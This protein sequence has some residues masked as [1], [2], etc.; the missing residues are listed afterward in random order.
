MSTGIPEID[1]APVEVD[2]PAYD[3]DTYIDDTRDAT[4]PSDAEVERV[5]DEIEGR[6]HVPAGARP[7][8][9]GP[10]ERGLSRFDVDRLVQ[11]DPLDLSGAPASQAA[12][13]DDLF[14]ALDALRE[15]ESALGMVDV[16]RRDAERAAEHT[17]AEALAAG[18]PPKPAKAIDRDGVREHRQRVVRVAGGRL[19]NAR[20]TYDAAVVGAQ[21]ARRAAL[22]DEAATARAE[23]LDLLPVAAAAFD[24]WRGA[25][26]AREQVEAELDP[27]RHARLAHVDRDASGVLGRGETALAAALALARSGH[28]VLNG[29]VW[30]ND[31]GPAVTPAYVRTWAAKSGSE[32]ALWWLAV[33]E[34]R[35]RFKVSRWTQGMSTLVE[36]HG[37]QQGPPIPAPWEPEPKR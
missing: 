1:N 23:V 35:E 8:N 24:R 10:A 27:A 34:Y 32:A 37:L 30:D 15:A 12:A 16:E 29:T 36:A 22:A 9:V 7:A 4:P 26:R 11:V 6:S 31:P 18:K 2:E 21:P 13:H 25:V 5:V 20:A 17:I 28:P 33:L 14:A 19:A 3:S